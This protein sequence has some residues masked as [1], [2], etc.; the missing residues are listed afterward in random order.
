MLIHIILIYEQLNRYT[1]FVVT[2]RNPTNAFQIIMKR[3]NPIYIIN[4]SNIDNILLG[5]WFSVWRGLACNEWSSTVWSRETNY[6]KRGVITTVLC[7]IEN[8]NWFRIWQPFH[9]QIFIRITHFRKIKL[10]FADTAKFI[11]RALNST[12]LSD[13]FIMVFIYQ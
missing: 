8:R 5:T 3:L 10:F 1:W 6:G 9:I 12:N 7:F 13:R 2:C 11:S 4:P